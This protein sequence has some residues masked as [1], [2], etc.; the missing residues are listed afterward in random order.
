MPSGGF[1]QLLG[2]RRQ[3]RFTLEKLDRNLAA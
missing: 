1:P 2:K 3:G